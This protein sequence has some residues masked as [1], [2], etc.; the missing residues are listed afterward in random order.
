MKRTTIK[1]FAV[2]RPASNPKEPEWLTADGDWTKDRSQAIEFTLLRS[3]TMRERHHI[4]VAVHDVAG[5]FEAFMDLTQGIKN[6]EAVIVS[7]IQAELWPDGPPEATDD[8]EAAGFAELIDT[9]FKDYE[10]DL[11]DGWRVLCDMRDRLGFMATWRVLYVGPKGEWEDLVELEI[12]ESV[13]FAVWQAYVN[14]KV[15]HD[16][17][18]GLSSTRSVAGV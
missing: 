2:Q 14:A 15:E 6:A 16:R 18:K 7:H 9:R 12:D 8:K 1:P 11:K 13:F 5:G 3:P 17:G 4:D 10:G